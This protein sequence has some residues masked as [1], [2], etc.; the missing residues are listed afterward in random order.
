MKD[1]KLIVF[2]ILI[3]NIMDGDFKNPTFLSIIKSILLLV[4]L[5]LICR[6]ERADVDK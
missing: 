4:N 6:K 3:L 5:I 1:V 2:V